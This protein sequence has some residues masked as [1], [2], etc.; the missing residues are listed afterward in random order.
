MDLEMSSYKMV[1]FHFWLLMIMINKGIFQLIL[2]PVANI[3]PFS[4]AKVCLFFVFYYTFPIQFKEV[5][6]C[7]I[8][9]RD[10]IGNA[11]LMVKSISQYLLMLE[12]II[13]TSSSLLQSFF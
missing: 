4:K 7:F 9:I 3:V 12:F 8:F 11:H 1:K 2:Q 5:L 6:H 10:G 13:F